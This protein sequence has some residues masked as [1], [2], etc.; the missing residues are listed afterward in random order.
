[1]WP[2]IM[3]LES[4]CPDSWKNGTVGEDCLAG[5]DCMRSQAEQ[6]TQTWVPEQ[7]MITSIPCP[8]GSVLLTL[9][10][11]VMYYSSPWAVRLGA[12]F[13]THKCHAETKISWCTVNSHI[14]RKL[15]WAIVRAAHKTCFV[16]NLCRGQASN[17]SSYVKAS[18]WDAGLDWICMTWRPLCSWR[19]SFSRSD[20]SMLMY[21]TLIPYRYLRIVLCWRPLASAR[22]VARHK[23]VSWLA[24]T[25]RRL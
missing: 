17:S 7:P 6:A 10:W 13:W 24:S 20:R 5:W 23:S 4:G 14:Q 21:S 11:I 19:V 1:M 9:R 2:T 22:K 16:R 15:M 25:S 12:T 8:N 3:L 18:L